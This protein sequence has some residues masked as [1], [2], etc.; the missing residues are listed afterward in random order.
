[1]SFLERLRESRPLLAVELRP[2]RRDVSS[3]DS[4]ESWIDTYHAVRGLLDRDTLVL[5]T[6][7]AIG[8][9]E[10]ES[11]LHL[12]SNLGTDADP[13]RIA[14]I[15]T[16]KHALD[17]CLRF[18]QRAAELGHRALVVLGGD[19]HDGVPRCVEHA[20]ELRQI[21]H[22][23]SPALALG[24]WANPHSDVERQVAFLKAAEN[25]ADFFLTQ[26]V[27][28]YDPRPIDRFLEESSRQG[29]T[30]PALFGV[31]FYRS[32]TPRT[33]RALA[34]FFPVPEA[35]VRRDLARGGPGPVEV[36]ARTIA[37]LAARGVHRVYV[38]NLEAHS[39]RA[40]LD[41]IAERV[42]ALGREARG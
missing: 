5:L 2:P 33:L 11:L 21:I 24:G 32:P 30:L 41:R 8:Q 31:F 37:A 34:S 14:P 12:T 26:I 15:L 13:S 9:R 18:P 35:E 23:R 20:Y 16:C 40:T 22:R 42:E 10:E 39:A 27:S 36:C 3:R 38:S 28:H 19:Q 1:M 4:L 25:T 6:D 7:S 17:Y 29:L